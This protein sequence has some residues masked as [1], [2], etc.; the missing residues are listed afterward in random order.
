LALIS[1]VSLEKYARNYKGEMK[2]F[3]AWRER[4][5]TRADVKRLRGFYGDLR[6]FLRS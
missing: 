6:E 4:L 2:R 1:A 3:Y 5:N